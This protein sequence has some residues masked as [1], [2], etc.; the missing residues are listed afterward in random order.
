MIEKLAFNEPNNQFVSHENKK[1]EHKQ[2]EN[3]KSDNRINGKPSLL[4]VPRIMATACLPCCE[5]NKYEFIRRSGKCTVAISSAFPLRLPYGPYP[6]RILVYITTEAKVTNSREI[7]LGQSFARLFEDISKP[8]YAELNQTTTTLKEQTQRLFGAMINWIIDDSDMWSVE[9]MKVVQEAMMLWDPSQPEQCESAIKLDE[10][11]F[12]DIQQ[13]AFPVSRYVAETLSHFPLAFDIYCW[14]NYLYS[15]LLQQSLVT[16]QQLQEQF[17][18]FCVKEKVF[19]HRFK[20]AI[21]FVHDYYP[22]AQF[23]LTDQGLL[24]YRS[25][26]HIS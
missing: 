1:K 6:R 9:S 11:F 24:L 21:E 14:L 13:H 16:W 17:G 25:P 23:K 22:Q 5:L 12:N 18:K 19:K 3:R 15:F 8:V 2:Q 4:F 26:P 20:T 7:Y 10:R